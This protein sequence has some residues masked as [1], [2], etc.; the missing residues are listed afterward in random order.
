MYHGFN[1]YDS[2]EEIDYEG[3]NEDTLPEEQQELELHKLPPFL[4][5][6]RFSQRL[7]DRNDL[8]VHLNFLGDAPWSPTSSPN[9]YLSSQDHLQCLKGFIMSPNELVGSKFRVY[10]ARIQKNDHLYKW[11]Y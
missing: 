8:I 10:G 9:G 6:L 11:H 1:L 4:I 3:Y 2:D 5:R 7:R